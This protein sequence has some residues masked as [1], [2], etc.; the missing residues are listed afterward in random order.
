MRTARVTTIV[1]VVAV[2][3]SV[4]RLLQF[5]W[6]MPFRPWLDVL[7]WLAAAGTLSNVC[8]Y[9]AGVEHGGRRERARYR[10]S[11]RDRRATAPGDASLTRPAGSRKDPQYFRRVGD[12]CADANT[13]ELLVCGRCAVASCRHVL[14]AQTW[15]AANDWKVN[16]HGDL[17][18]PCHP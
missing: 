14:T 18:C 3:V 17:Y 6:G 5:A 4:V 2:A 11:R 16:P 12:Q 1:G 13:D 8:S 10:A 15:S 7:L 9:H